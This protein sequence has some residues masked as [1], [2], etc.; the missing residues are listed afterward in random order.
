MMA[1]MPTYDYL[2]T[3]CDHQ[4]EVVQSLSERPL[5]TCERCGGKLRRVYHPAGVLFKGPGF[6]STDARRADYKRGK[7]PPKVGEAERAR[8]GGEPAPGEAASGNEKPVSKEKPA[9]TALKSSDSE[10]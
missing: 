4:S 3:S 6:Y 10:S 5:E 1:T 8:S 7:G 9:A 2:C